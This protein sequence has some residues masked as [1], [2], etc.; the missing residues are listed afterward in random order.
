MT[1]SGTEKSRC[2]VTNVTIHRTHPASAKQYVVVCLCFALSVVAVWVGGIAKKLDQRSCQFVVEGLTANLAE[3]RQRT[4]RAWWR[5]SVR[6]QTRCS[7]VVKDALARVQ[8]LQG[9][10]SC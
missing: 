9:K 6:S 3:P 1:V 5:P 7:G 2:N 10:Q 4:V 8:A